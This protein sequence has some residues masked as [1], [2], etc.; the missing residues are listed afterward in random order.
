MNRGSSV[1]RHADEH[2]IPEGVPYKVVLIKDLAADMEELQQLARTN[3]NRLSAFKANGQASKADLPAA[4][5]YCILPKGKRIGRVAVAGVSMPQPRRMTPNVYGSASSSSPSLTM[6]ASSPESYGPM[7]PGAVFCSPSPA[8]LPQLA[9]P[10][11]LVP[12]CQLQG[13]DGSTIDPTL[14]STNGPWIDDV[15]QVPVEPQA[16]FNKQTWPELVFEEDNNPFANSAFEQYYGMDFFQ[17]PA[18]DPVN[19]DPAPSMQLPS[20]D[21]PYPF[22]PQLSNDFNSG[23]FV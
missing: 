18:F 20:S 19:F 14:L 13:W 4:P 7:T 21:L 17:N 15:P 11:P 8:P 3:R 5:D 2:R 10:L 9:L 1:Q 23:L 12:E 22:W 16:D 6:G